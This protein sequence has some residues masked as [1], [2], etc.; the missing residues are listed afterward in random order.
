MSFFFYISSTLETR[1]CCS[2][3]TYATLDIDFN[4]NRTYLK[5]SVVVI[6]LSLSSTRYIVWLHP[7]TTFH[8]CLCTE[9]VY[10]HI[11]DIEVVMREWQI[12][13]ICIPEHHSLKSCLTD[14]LRFSLIYHKSQILNLIEIFTTFFAKFYHFFF[15]F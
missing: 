7:W 3:D 8:R 10:R 12:R 14:R 1:P 15:N 2:S 11:N 9:H 4:N 5:S 6:S 13:Q